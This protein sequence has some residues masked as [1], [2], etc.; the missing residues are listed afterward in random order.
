MM[1]NKNNPGNEAFALGSKLTGTGK[2]KRW[3]GEIMRLALNVFVRRHCSASWRGI[4]LGAV[5]KR[6]VVETELSHPSFAS[7]SY[8]SWD[9]VLSHFVLDPS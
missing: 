8:W 1:D 6:R 9:A 4:T 3:A 2:T 5:N 7:P